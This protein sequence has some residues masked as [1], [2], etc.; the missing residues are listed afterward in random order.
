MT[1]T[2]ILADRVPQY[3]ITLQWYDDGD[4]HTIAMRESEETDPEGLKEM[5]HEAAELVL[6]MTTVLDKPKING[7]H[8]EREEK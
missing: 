3:E 1:I 8:H 2:P 4:G 5:L 6:T 7:E